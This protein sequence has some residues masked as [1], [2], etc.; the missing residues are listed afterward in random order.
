MCSSE[1]WIWN[2]K[3]QSCCV[4]VGGWTRRA[5]HFSLWGC[6]KPAPPFCGSVFLK[7]FRLFFSFS[8]PNILRHVESW[9]LIGWGLSCG[10]FIQNNRQEVKDK[11][12]EECVRSRVSKRLA[13]PNRVVSPAHVHWKDI[14]EVTGVW[15]ELAWGTRWCETAGVV[16]RR[17]NNP[18]I[19]IRI[20]RNGLIERKMSADLSICVCRCVCAHLYIKKGH[21]IWTS[22]LLFWIHCHSDANQST[23]LHLGNVCALN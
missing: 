7:W 16:Q 20:I 14:W 3:G 11:K 5:S 17:W 15:C 21:K 12:F 19:L 9:V 22:Q 4:C 10:F 2:H 8:M 6:W 18:L 1:Q 13:C 23:L